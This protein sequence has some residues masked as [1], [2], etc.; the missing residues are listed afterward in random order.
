MK[1]GDYQ[2]FILHAQQK[3]LTEYHIY[4]YLTKLAKSKKNRHI[5][6]QISEEEL[7][8]HNFWKKYS[9][10][11]VKP[12]QSQ[13]NKHKI[14]ARIFGLVFSIQLMEKQ[15][16]LMKKFYEE[17]KD[18]I[19]GIKQIENDEQKHE[20]QLIQ[21]IQEEKLVYASSIVLGLD[22]ALVEMT[23]S[24]AGYTLAFA[25]HNI[26]AITGLITGIAASLS[27]ASS[28]YLSTKTELHSEKKPL[29]AA[30][31]TGLTYLTAVLL[32]VS[33]FFIFNNIFISLATTI[34][35]A[36]SL[37]SLF[38]YYISVAKQLNFKKRFFEM[39]TISLGIALFSFIVGYLINRILGI[40]I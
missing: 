13:I 2:K 23:G 6:K 26:V 8:H 12:N 40:S 9:K 27:M 20:Q 18:K 10:T 14:L 29:K 7:V 32:L 25:N 19:L 16:K 1:K 39:A 24:L 37:I 22:D 11:D 5:L 30:V 21:L 15:E 36:I 38:T 17:C 35:F 3:E 33:P 4:K 28:E 34:F 31:Y